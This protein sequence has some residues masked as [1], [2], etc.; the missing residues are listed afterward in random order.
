MN[1]HKIVTIV[2]I[3]I[4]V[5][6]R[7]FRCINIILKTRSEALVQNNFIKAIEK[8]TVTSYFTADTEKN[9]LIGSGGRQAALKVA[10][11]NGKKRNSRCQSSK[12]YC[13]VSSHET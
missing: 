12:L 9:R 6:L 2:H 3:T 13:F 5:Q 11:K 7:N 8:N 1:M 10:S 4:R